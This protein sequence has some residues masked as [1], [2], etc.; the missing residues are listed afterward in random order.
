MTAGSRMKT[1]PVPAFYDSGNAERWHFRPSEMAVMSEAE[2]FRKLHGITPSSADKV[3]IHLLLIDVQKDFCF[4]EGTLYV[5]GRSGR[6]A[7]E[8]SDRLARFIYR[9]LAVITET[10][11][12]MDT[13]FPHQIFF[14][15]FWLDSLGEPLT[16]HREITTSDIRSGRVRPNPA[17]AAWL[18][19]GDYGWLLRQVDFYC[20]ELE[21]AGKYKLYLWPPHCLLGG[22]GHVLAGVLQ[23][24]RLFHAFARSAKAAIEVK[25]GNALTENYSVLSPEVLLRHDGKPLSERN[26]PFIKTLLGSS[27]V[28][29]AGQAASHCVKS[30]I[31][32]LISEIKSQDE[33]LANKVYILRDCM[34]AVTVPAGAGEGVLFD[35][36]AQAE[37]A[38]KRFESSGMHV[39]DSTQPLENWPGMEL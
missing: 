12:T 19:G 31:D 18:C 37:E 28:I 9:N 22:E 11:C 16:P 25:G 20:L 6:G 5:G 2:R 32:D 26:A 24:A 15:S 10:T 3:T 13:H 1:L 30:S 14:P 33:S 21:K 34:S 8:D 38:L 36:T 29:I 7:I 23:E 4:P 35:F 27:Y 39:I 17:M